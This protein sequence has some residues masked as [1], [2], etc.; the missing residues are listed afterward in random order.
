MRATEVPGDVLVPEPPLYLL[1]QRKRD[2]GGEADWGYAVAKNESGSMEDAASIIEDVAGFRFFAWPRWQRRAVLAA[3]KIL[4]AQLASCLRAYADVKMAIRSARRTADEEL[5]E[6]L[7]KGSAASDQG[8]IEMCG[9]FRLLLI[10]KWVAS[11]SWIVPLCV[12]LC[13]V[14]RL[15]Q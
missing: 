7:M 8:L 15:R 12:L 2:Q 3:K 1:Q 10:Y 11:G 13:P 9:S 6:L 5:R 14:W 4:P